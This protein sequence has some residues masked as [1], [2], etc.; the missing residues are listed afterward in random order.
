MQAPG[1]D[2]EHTSDK[3]TVATNKLEK[4]QT[5]TKRRENRDHVHVDCEVRRTRGLRRVVGV[6]VTLRTRA[7]SSS[8]SSTSRW[9]TLTCTTWGVLGAR[10]TAC[11]FDE[12]H[13]VTLG[14]AWGTGPG[15]GAGVGAGRGVEQG[16]GVVC[17]RGGWCAVAVA[18]EQAKEQE[19]DA[20][21]AVV[22]I[23][24]A[25][26]SV[27]TVVAAVVVGAVLPLGLP[28]RLL[29]GD[30]RMG[31]AW[32]VAGAP[33]A[34]GTT[35]AGPWPGAGAASTT[36]ATEATEAGAVSRLVYSIMARLRSRRSC[37]AS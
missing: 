36:E 5:A 10:L 18:V 34:A 28:A 20:L 35:D 14:C 24:G 25:N 37:T 17:E 27:V 19:V 7:L 26:E 33:A 3:I 13:G 30:R 6:T 1:E 15:A 4:Q 29:L 23:M 16:L 2:R 11:D 22:V 9:I 32:G 21:M 12:R 31:T 8:S